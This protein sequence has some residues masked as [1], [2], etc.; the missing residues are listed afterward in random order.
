MIAHGPNELDRALVPYQDHAC[1]GDDG[2]QCI[3]DL[4]A[5]WDRNFDAILN[6]IEALREGKP[7]AIRLVN[8][9]NVFVSEPEIAA[10]LE[11][12][13]ATDAGAQMFSALTDAICKNAEKHEAACVDVRPIL[14]GPSLDQKVDENS[15]ASMKAV[16]DALLATGLRE[17]D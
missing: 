2:R 3:R 14:N 11:D 1:G 6:E 7:T 5:L 12:G 8:A 9:A 4:G 16:A 17:F 15:E 13:F 10:G